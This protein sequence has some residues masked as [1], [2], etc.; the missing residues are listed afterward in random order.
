MLASTSRK[1]GGREMTSN[2]RK[3]MYRIREGGLDARGKGNQ[4]Q[5]KQRDRMKK[6]PHRLS[7]SDI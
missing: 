2:E 4:H 1:T 7:L 6:I 3:E 5:A